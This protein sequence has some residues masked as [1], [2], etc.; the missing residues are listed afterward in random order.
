MT[1]TL[2]TMIATAQILQDDPAL[3]A[4][5]R[6]RLFAKAQFETGLPLERVSLDA[7][8][9]RIEF[10]VQHYDDP[11]AWLA[12]MLRRERI[13]AHHDR[14][15]R[16]MGIAEAIGDLVTGRPPDATGKK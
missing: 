6:T 11:Q 12:E 10:S 15:Q 3:I 16:T 5:V 8:A 2:T 14:M 7:N 9:D 13:I 1:D 4:Y